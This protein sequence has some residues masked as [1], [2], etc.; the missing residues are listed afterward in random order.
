MAKLKQDVSN[1]VVKIGVSF[2]SEFYQ[3]VF[4]AALKDH[5][6]GCHVDRVKAHCV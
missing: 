4:I 3:K 6:R 1:L 5:D 2:K